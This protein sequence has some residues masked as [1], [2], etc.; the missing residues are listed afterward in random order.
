[1]EYLMTYGWAIL[2][3][4]VVLAVLFSLGVFNASL[5]S[6]CIAQSGYLCQTL[7]YKAGTGALT[8][9]FGQS[10]GTA[11][12]SAN[13]YF[14]PQ[15]SSYVGGGA[16]QSPT[17]AI[18]GGLINGATNSVTI[19]IPSTIAANTLGTSLA[20]YLYVNYTVTSGG[21]HYVTSI[22]TVTTKAQ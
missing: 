16:S 8:F 3:I 11:W 12:T 15:G 7:F 2:I 4:A 1:M 19:S 6:A 13:V 20:G 18:S 14:V 10:T 17:S 21:T 5:P 22:A 9:T